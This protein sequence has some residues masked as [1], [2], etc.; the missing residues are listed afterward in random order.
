MAEGRGM[1]G[2]TSHVTKEILPRYARLDDRTWKYEAEGN[3]WV[4]VVNLPIWQ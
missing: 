1:S 2:L 3:N 4:G